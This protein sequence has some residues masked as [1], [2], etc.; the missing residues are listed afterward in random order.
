MKNVLFPSI[1]FVSSSFAWDLWALFSPQLINMKALLPKKK[2]CILLTKIW[3]LEQIFV[4][5]VL[6]FYS[7]YI[8]IY[9]L[10][11]LLRLLGDTKTYSVVQCFPVSSNL[12]TQVTSISSVDV[13]RFVDLHY[14]CHFGA[15][16]NEHSSA[17][18]TY[19]VLQFLTE[20]FF[21]YIFS[22]WKLMRSQ[23]PSDLRNP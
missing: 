19:S 7:I 5:K 21:R 18:P 16:S 4:W 3:N 20:N 10:Q 17:Y 11:F 14:K 1:F 8:Y 9:Y 23:T 6:S 22:F 13:R 2:T 15:V 12:L